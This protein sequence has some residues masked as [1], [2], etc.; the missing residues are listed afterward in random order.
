MVSYASPKNLRPAWTRRDHPIVRQYLRKALPIRFGFLIVG[1]A[2]V[3]FLLF[4]GLSLPMLYF[5]F[6]LIILLQIAIH[7]SDKIH[8]ARE[9]YTWD[10]VLATPY[11]QREVLLSLWAATVWQVN[12]TWLMLFYRLLQG[13]I[14]TG[15]IVF[16]LLFAE[17]PVIH[18]TLV[19][20]G[21]TLVIAIQP[22]ADMYYSGMTGLLSANLTYDRMAAY[23]LAVGAV[24]VYWFVWLGLTG[25]V[26][27][28]NAGQLELAAILS[29]LALP[30]V[31][32]G[33]AGYV[34]FRLAERLARLQR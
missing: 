15:V 13:M 22:F 4:G 20:V 28:T 1:G 26:L 5:L 30:V 27:V 12:S 2:V 17:I 21:G 6:S 24:L 29:V 10:L 14:V 31:L 18:W 11:S 19:L 9:G 7:T 8:Q 32:P 34:F 16:S 3:L 23:G 25:L 33:L